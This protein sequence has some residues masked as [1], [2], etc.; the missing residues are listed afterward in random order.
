MQRFVTVRR[1]LDQGLKDFLIKPEVAVKGFSRN[2]LRV[3]C[4]C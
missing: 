3:H 4:F 1:D 2:G